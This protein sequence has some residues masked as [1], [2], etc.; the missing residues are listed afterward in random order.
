MIVF[1]DTDIIIKLAA[2]DLLDEA[3]AVLD[4]SLDEVHVLRLE[5]AKLG[6][7]DIIDD[8]GQLASDRAVTFAKKAKKIKNV[9]GAEFLRLHA[10][11]DPGEATLIAATA[12]M[13]FD[14]IITGDR[15]ALKKLSEDDRCEAAVRRVEGKVVCLEQQLLDI[16]NQYGFEHVRA[17]MLRSRLP[18]AALVRIFSAGGHASSAE[19]ERRLRERVEDIR[20]STGRLLSGQFGA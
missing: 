19:V 12:T 8:Y 10:V 5:Q 2:L 11:I 15:K 9:D 4:T 18:D 16:I 1:S 7:A 20:S 14:T 6:A 3:M 13:E 17:R